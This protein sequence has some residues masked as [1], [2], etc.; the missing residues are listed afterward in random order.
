M[1]FPDICRYWTNINQHLLDMLQGTTRV[2][3]IR[4]EDLVRQQEQTIT[5]VLHFLDLQVDP[6][7]FRV[8]ES[9]AE[10]RFQSHGTSKDPAASIGRWQTELSDE[11]KQIAHTI[12]GELLSQFGY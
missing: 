1:T 2:L 7:I 6:N 8:L 9:K 4:Y 5:D 12:Q 11:E 3:R 10:E